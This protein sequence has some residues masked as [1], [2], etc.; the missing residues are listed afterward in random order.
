MV[1]GRSIPLR[2]GTFYFEPLEGDARHPIRLS[3]RVDIFF[4]RAIHA[5]S[6]EA[7]GIGLNGF[8]RAQLD[9]DFMDR[10]F[11]REIESGQRARLAGALRVNTDGFVAAAGPYLI[12]I[13]PVEGRLVEIRYFLRTEASVVPVVDAAPADPDGVAFHADAITAWGGDVV[14]APTEA[15]RIGEDAGDA[16]HGL[17]LFGIRIREGAAA[18]AHVGLRVG[19]ENGK[20]Q[21]VGAGV[22]FAGPK[23][24]KRWLLTRVD[25]GGSCRRLHEFRGDGLA[26]G[27]VGGTHITGELHV[28]HIECGADFVIAP[29][30]AILG[31]L[32][33]DLRPRDTE[34]VA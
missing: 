20:V 29:G 18:G 8:V 1:P 11:G 10:G 16:A 26:Q 3:E 9:F 13:G 33:L 12:G 17:S 24:A 7:H 19:T 6:E 27:V 23:V 31:Q 32:R 15:A 28:R 30:F 22:A 14:A 34:K 25:A 2:K 4:L 5:G 21:P